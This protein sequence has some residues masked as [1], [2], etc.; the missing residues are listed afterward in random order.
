VGTAIVAVFKAPINA[1]IS[2]ID[3]IKLPSG[4]HIKTWHGIPDG[5]SVAWSNPFNIPMLAAGGIVNSPTL[6]VIGEAGPEAV[7]P[8]S[9]AGAGGLGGGPVFS[10]TVNGVVGNERDVAMKIGHELQQ[11]KNRGLSF[12]LA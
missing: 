9:G 12:G 5:F 7:I 10:V 1:V 8:L 4:I 6:A 3:A 2:L 11:L